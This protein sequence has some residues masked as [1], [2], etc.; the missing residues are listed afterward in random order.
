MTMP[1][2][3][4]I[5]SR[6]TPP[7]VLADMEEVA[8]FLSFLGWGLSSGGADGADNAFLDGMMKSPACNPATMLRIFLVAEH[9]EKY[10][11]N[12]ALGFYN[13]LEFTET[14]EAAGQLSMAARGSWGGLKQTG[15]NLHTRNAFQVFHHTLRHPVK[16]VVCWAK[17]T[18][19]KGKFEGGTN[20]AIQLALSHDIP[21][22]NL[23]FDDV[24]ERIR[25]FIDSTRLRLGDRLWIG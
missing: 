11:P 10:R 23:Y 16:Q 20:T 14:W 22:M 18:G 9:W 4:G 12:P 3:A 19:N 8:F 5:G 24:R 25:K 21:V 15:I 13:S 2:Y 6:D 7:D 17:P 1:F